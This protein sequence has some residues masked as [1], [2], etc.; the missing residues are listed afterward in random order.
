MTKFLLI[1]LLIPVFC[2]SQTITPIANIQ[3]SISVYNGQIVTIQ[4]IITIGAGVTN[5]LQMNA[6]IQDDS[7]KGI[8]LFA[9]DIPP[10]LTDLVRGN[11]LEVTGEVD[12]YN[13]VTEI[14]DFSWSVLSTGNPEPEPIDVNLSLNLNGYEGTLVLAVGEITDAYWAGGGN[15]V[16]ISDLEN[17]S[18]TIRIWDS[19]GITIDDY[20]IGDIIEAVGVGGMYNN[21]FQILAGYQDQIRLGEFDIY[22]YGD[23]ADPQSGFPVEVTFSYPETFE[24]VTLFW[25]TNE[26]LEFNQLP[27]LLQEAR[28][29]LYTTNI[30]AQSAG[31]K[32]EFYITAVDTA[33]VETTFNSL[34]YP[35]FY[36]VVPVNKTKAVLNVPPKAFNPYM[37]ESFPIEFASQIGDKAILR[38]Y[39]AEGKLVFQPQNIIIS[40]N[41]GNNTYNWN[42]KDKDGKLVPIG[43]YICY[44]EVIN[45]ETGKKKTAK[46]PIVVG[47]PLK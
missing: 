39:N 8:E 11:E 14:K 47:V 4:G 6:F 29:D 7:G 5:N 31:T 21:A 38:I 35:Y 45:P 44:L 3:D 36:Y 25:K 9:F 12:E 28:D 46:A 33:G 20:E 43:L 1:L 37:G 16:I 32:V 19:T 15:N 24:P 40:G 17:Y 18:T 41:S 27:M 13:G 23:I 2:Y 10:Y 42:G 26:D 30:P 34:L 22:P